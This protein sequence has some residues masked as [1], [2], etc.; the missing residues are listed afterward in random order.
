MLNAFF[1]RIVRFIADWIHS[2][3][4]EN[5]KIPQSGIV[6]DFFFLQEINGILL[7]AA[8]DGLG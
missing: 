2:I 6:S 3:I 4:L 7:Q 5:I 8:L 1:E